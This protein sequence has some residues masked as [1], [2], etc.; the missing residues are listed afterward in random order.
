MLLG[1]FG[2]PAYWGTFPP[3]SNFLPHLFRPCPFT[4]CTVF[5][6]WA[7]LSFVV[8]LLDMMGNDFFYS[9]GKIWHNGDDLCHFFN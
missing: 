7:L 4:L 9:K 2:P 1:C 5:S 3:G 6:R 8:L